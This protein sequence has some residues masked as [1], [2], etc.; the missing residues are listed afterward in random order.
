MRYCMSLPGMDYKISPSLSS[1]GPPPETGACL[2][3]TQ[4]SSGFLRIVPRASA[5]SIAAASISFPSPFFALDA[6]RSP[7]A[8]V[9]LRFG[10]E[11]SLVAAV[12]SPISWP[13]PAASLF[14]ARGFLLGF[15][16]A[17]ARSLFT[18][19]MEASTV[20][21]ATMTSSQSSAKPSGNWRPLSYAPAHISMWHS[22]ASSTTAT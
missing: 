22:V 13:L 10:R 12:S 8:L 20:V 15:A 21:N 2:S 7:L 11:D 17:S 9:L 1:P 4:Y 6:S 16:A 5:W 19:S 14:F 18:W 3:R